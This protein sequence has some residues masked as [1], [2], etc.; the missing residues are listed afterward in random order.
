M[1]L[2]KSSKESKPRKSN[3][4]VTKSGKTIKLHTSLSDKVKASR[5]QKALRKAERMRGMPKSRIKRFFYKLHPKRL[6]QYWWSREGG[7]MALKITGIGL[8][9]MFILLIGVFAYFRKDLPNLRDISGNNIGGSIRYYDRTGETLLWEDYD[10]VKRIPVEGDQISDY[11]KQAT[12]ALEDRDFFKHGGF[13]LKGITRAA[14]ANVAGG[15]T[16]QG[17]STITQ[18]L[19]KLSLDWSSD[20]SYARKVKELI[21]AVEMERSYSK[22]EILTGYLNTAPYGNIQYGAEVAAQ[23]YFHKPAKDLTLP[24]SVF[25]ASIPQAPS[26]YSPYGAYFAE[27]NS[28]GETGAEALR[29]RMNYTLDIMHEMGFISRED[30]DGAKEFDILPTVK[31]TESRYTGIKAPHFVLAAKEELEKKWSA[32]TI[33]RSG[34]KVTT[35]VDLNLQAIAEE[36]VTKGIAQVKRQG[37]DV[38]AFVAEDVETGQIVAMVGGP[39]FTNPDY[40]QNNYARMPLPPGSS[41]KPYDYAALME[42]TNNVGAGTVLYDTRGALPGYPCTSDSNCL[43]NYD[44]RYPGPVTVRYALGG[45]RNVPAIKAMLIAGVDKTIETATTLMNANNPDSYGY[46]CYQPGTTDFIPVNEDQCY[47]SSA[48]GDG[49]YLKMDEHVHGLATLSRNG[50]NIPRAY[51]LKIDDAANKSVYEWKLEG[52]SQVIREDT[53]YI[54]NDMMS[55]PRAS[56]M[57]R[58]RHRM[59]GAGGQWKVAI[60]TGTTNDSKDGW[61]TGFSSKYAAVVWVG[62]NKR[63]VEMSGFM[64][65]MTQPIFDGWMSRV[66]K[67]IEPKDWPK[68]NGVQTL[69]AFVVTAHVGASSQE[70]SSST[71]LYP[72]WY[73]K[74]NNSN[75]KRTIDVISGKLATECTPDPAKKEETGGIASQHSGDTFVDAGTASDEKDDV[76]LCTD[77]RPSVT[78]TSSLGTG[79]TYN[80]SANVTGGTHPLAGNADKGAGKVEFIIGGQVV[81]SAELT[82]PGLYTVAYTPTSGG[83]QSLSARVFDSVLY[84]AASNPVTIEVIGLSVTSMG[85]NYVFSWTNAS[86]SVGFYRSNGSSFT[87]LGGGGSCTASQASVGPAGT[88]V[89]ARTLNGVSPTI[90]VN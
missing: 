13:D 9:A 76:H 49:A 61:I 66:H 5:D 2:K 41:F 15:S 87:C 4:H 50:L 69:P 43:R 39:D 35:T 89:Y 30:R 54:I 3:V 24:E 42:S 82:G 33:I 38:A 77:V 57:G 53:A 19:V 56:Y 21:I 67:D 68:P 23:D 78:V 10:A 11:L 37:G 71:D 74:R 36:E 14:W 51:I 32:E 59:P 45:S 28:R 48:I 73:Q 60:K 12:I 25:L 16:S 86:G 46:R 83:D 58:K 80:L 64:E 55:D 7:I 6:K 84:D 63:Q 17:G 81:G 22:E 72:S 79:G 26:F 62:H 65:N 85:S 8:V 75:Q 40:G 27:E 18:Q 44:R 70:P 1:A 88:G 47:A 90:T 31:Q 52:G 34:W 20:K 29:G